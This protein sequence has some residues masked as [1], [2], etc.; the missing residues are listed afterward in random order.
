MDFKKPRGTRDFLFDEMEERKYV[1]NTIRSVVESYGFKEIKTPIF[2]DLELFTTRSGEGIKDELYHF[3]DKGGRDLALRPEIT[4]SV[5]RLYNNNLQRE[6]KPLKM[7][8]FGS[9]FRYERPQAGRYRQFWQF[10]IEVIGGT[11][12]YNEAEIIAMANDALSKINI[13]NYEIAIGHLGIIKGVL[14]KINIPSEIQTQIIASIDKQDYELLDK[15]LTDNNVTEEYKTIINDLINVKGSRE[16]LE[17]FK[18]TLKN[19]PESYEAAEEL[20]NI[21]ETLEVFGFNDYTVNLSI[22][23]GLDYYTGLVFEIYVPDL[24]A[25]KQITG[26]GTYNL[27]GLFDAEEVES[28]GF[29][30]GF[31]RIMEAYKR[32]N[33]QLPEN[34]S[35][36]VLVIP[37]K[38]EFK[39]EA[40]LIAQQL[41][42]ENIIADIDLKG[43]KLK[44]NLSYAN[45]HKF[46]K[47][48]M[49]GQKEVEDNTV[50][51]KDMA[52]GDQVTIPQ[53]ELITKIQE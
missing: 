23:R 25:E 53:D 39:N 10:G 12:I 3:Q 19:I 7:Y 6:A 28:T 15:L 32:Q 41:R 30:F 43:K 8:Y 26:G 17:A 14:S 31:D 48:I 20:N 35:P 40:I 33:I 37:V 42:R 13:Q 52:S 5:A 16:D 45:T 11:P 46:N 47:V 50:T 36:R 49:I 1:E 18:S 27:M 22:A 21:L 9:C 4:A 24:G 51:L 2:E 29:A 44:K 38:K 34:D